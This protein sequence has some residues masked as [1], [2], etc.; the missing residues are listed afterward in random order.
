MR[1]AVII[2]AILLAA[3]GKPATSSAPAAEAAA[4]PTETAAPPPAEPAAPDEPSV[5][6]AAAPAGVY[7]N[8]PGHSYIAF[9]YDHQG[10][11]YPIVRWG[12]WTAELD[13]NPAEPTQS[14][15]SATIDIN[16]ID[17]GVADLDNHLKSADFFDAAT[18]P[19]ITF[20]STSLQ[21][22]GPNKGVMT[23][24]LTIK[25]VTKPVALDVKINRAAD[26]GFAKAYKLGF[27]GTGKLKRSDFGVDRYVPIVGDEVEFWIEAEFLKAKDQP[28]QP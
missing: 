5:D 1:Y 24:D 14:G 27:S 13:W 6:L 7:A 15:V 19:A 9:A 12:G 16:R 22:T 8:D 17:T 18:Y 20:K 26:D 21:V 3:C 28:A 11:S 25:D 4:A 10:Y 2:S 23:G